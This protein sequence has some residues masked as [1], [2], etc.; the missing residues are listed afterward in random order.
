MADFSFPRNEQLQQEANAF[1][2]ENEMCHYFS[3]FDNGH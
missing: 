3:G 2:S 1:V